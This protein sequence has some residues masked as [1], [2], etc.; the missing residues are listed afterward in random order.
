[1]GESYLGIDVLSMAIEIEKTGIQF[2]EE[3]Q[4]KI[5]DDKVLKVFEYLAEEE[6]KHLDTFEEMLEKA[7]R[8]GVNNSF[9]EPS[10]SDFINELISGRVFP[11]QEKIWRNESFGLK[12]AIQLA[13]TLEKDSVLFFHEML[14]VTSHHD[15]DLVK[16]ILDEERDHLLRILDLKRALKV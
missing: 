6:G 12:E 11:T 13:L 5:K 15:I 3:F 16:Q 10:T 9:I 1:M 14:N 2:Y 8:A 4:K 7:K